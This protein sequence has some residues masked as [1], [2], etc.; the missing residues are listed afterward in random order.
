MAEQAI[1]TAPA[2]TAAPLCT[3]GGPCTFATPI[4]A[5]DF[6]GALRVAAA[7]PARGPEVGKAL[8]AEKSCQLVPAGRPLGTEATQ[9]AQVVY[10]TEAGLHLG[11]LPVGVFSA[12]ETAAAAGPERPVPIRVTTRGQDVML[13]RRGPA[14][15]VVRMAGQG[16]GSAAGLFRSGPA[17]RRDFCANSVGDSSAEKKRC[18]AKYRNDDTF[19]VH[20]D[21]GSRVVTVLDRTY[22]LH[23]RPATFPSDGNID[24]DRKWLWQDVATDEWLDGSTPSHEPQV[25]SAFNALC[26]GRRPDAD[27]GFVLRDPAAQFP[28]SLRGTWAP[29][30]Q[31]CA[32]VGRGQDPQ[33]VEDALTVTANDVRGI[34]YQETLNQIRRTDQG[35]VA[36]VSWTDDGDSGL[37]SVRYEPAGASLFVVGV[38]GTLQ[39]VRCGT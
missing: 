21:C 2:G 28:P 30:A 39:L 31:T 11:Y 3:V 24:P 22:R 9:S 1:P 7:G 27:H 18:M 12:T 32:K 15:V 10:A 35:W 26:P 36:D 16:T 8:V 17:E 5:C 20:A 23:P 29:N 25:D 34:E 19:A 14:P 6:E 38:S 37:A 13:F 4:F 33:A